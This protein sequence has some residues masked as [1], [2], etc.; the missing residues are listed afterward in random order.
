MR[1]KY[2]Q[3]R[4]ME[5]LLELKQG[6]KGAHAFVNKDRKPE[7]SEI[8]QLPNNRLMEL[9]KQVKEG[10]TKA[11][12]TLSVKYIQLVIN[13]AKDFKNNNLTDLELILKGNSGLIKA[14]ENFDNSRGIDFSAYA[15]WSVRQEIIKAIDEYEY[16]KPMPLNKI[17][18]LSKKKYWNQHHKEPVNQL[19]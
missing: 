12:E 14:A 3:H 4:I 7:N 18:L 19:I 16:L 10:N 2:F 15:S 5:K 17:G 8:N 9:F 6:A 11:M 13:I 1:D